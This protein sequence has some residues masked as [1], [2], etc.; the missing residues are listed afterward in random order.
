[1]PAP[2]ILRNLTNPPKKAG[3][4]PKIAT[5]SDLR[6]GAR[7]AGPIDPG[8]IDSGFPDFS[9]G[10]LSVASLTAINPLPRFTDIISGPAT[11]LGDGLG[12]GVIVTV[13]GQGFGDQQGQVYFTDN[14]GVKRPAAHIYYW[15]KADGQAPGGP[16]QL[17]RSHLMYEI[18][19]SIPSGS[20]TGPGVI[21]VAKAG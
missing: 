1:M 2:I 20:A 12:D 10:V 14:L 16:A 3:E 13:W 8:P 21:S 5:R 17:W 18:A 4:S 6:D 11:R 7:G 19:F 15:K 9:N